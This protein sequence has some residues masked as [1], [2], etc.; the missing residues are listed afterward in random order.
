VGTPLEALR[1]VVERNRRRLA[2]VR[3]GQEE[4]L[5]ALARQARREIRDRLEAI[6]PARFSV[7]EARFVAAQI[8]DVIDDVGRRVGVE[9]GDV[10]EDLGREAA[11]ISRD[12]VVEQLGAWGQEHP[13]AQR[14]RARAEEA[15]LSLDAGLLQRFESSRER[16]GLQRISAMRD[17]LAVGLL[18]NETAIQVSDR[19]AAAVD[20]EP[21]QAE[22]IVRTEQSFAFH[23]Q[24]DADT[25]EFLDDEADEWR[26]E[27]VATFDSR[28]GE[29]SKFVNGQRRK[30]GERFRDNEGRVYMYPPNRPNDRETVIMVPADVDEVLSAVTVSDRKS[31]VAAGKDWA[32]SIPDEQRA[33][34]KRWALSS[35]PIRAASKRP[36][37]P[38]SKWIHDQEGLATMREALRTAPMWTSEIY[39]GINTKRLLGADGRPVKLEP[40]AT[41][42]SNAISS[43]SI[44]PRVGVN[45]ATDKGLLL[46]I[47]PKEPVPYIAEALPAF[48]RGEEEAVLDTGRNF[49]V[50]R[51]DKKASL[52]GIGG[53]RIK[54]DVVYLEEF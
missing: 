6:D 48:T 38:H 54:A 7:Q 17:A 34:L 5:L 3:P 45:F 24:W 1:E 46:V 9:T 2:A 16:Y 37:A 11:G 13:G 20:L 30:F 49:R 19:L 36:D 47:Q 29:D 15:A 25:V 43:A 51:R 4:R 23:R 39:R 52:P 18:Q 14:M 53:R 22:R 26:K 31:A 50:V 21:W 42:T 28:T 44:S 32:G 40:G 27:L 35:D 33:A 41:W 8:E 10:V 12:D